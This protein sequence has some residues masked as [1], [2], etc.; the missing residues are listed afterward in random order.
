[1][2]EQERP[3]KRRRF[4][5]RTLWLLFALGLLLGSLGGW[6]YLRWKLKNRP[7]AG[8]RPESR[9]RPDPQSRPPVTRAGGLRLRRR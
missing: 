8:S 5:K 2:P 3:A 6:L 9:A 7:V 1:M 4:T